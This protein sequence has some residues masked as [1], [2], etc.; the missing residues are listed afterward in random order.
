MLDDFHDCMFN[1]VADKHRLVHLILIPGLAAYLSVSRYVFREP[2]FSSFN[3][4][5]TANGGI[6]SLFF[7]SQEISPGKMFSV[8]YAFA[9]EIPI[10]PFEGFLAMLAAPIPRALFAMK[11]Y[12]TSAIFTELYSPERWD[13]TKSESTISGYGDLYLQFGCV[14]ATIVAFL[15]GYAFFRICIRLLNNSPTA[16]ITWIPIA[17]GAMYTFFRADVFNVGLVLWPTFFVHVTHRAL[18]FMIK[19]ARSW[20]RQK[21]AMSADVG[22]AS[23]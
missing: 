2:G 19:S 1:E 7:S 11:P 20:H 15:L 16:T 14:G 12:G 18:A 10:Y 6:L 4:F 3:E 23:A 21:M 22:G 9:D 8:I 17:L 13:L 5:L